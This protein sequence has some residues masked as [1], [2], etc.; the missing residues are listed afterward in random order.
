[1]RKSIFAFSMAICLCLALFACGKSGQAGPAQLRAGTYTGTG[2]GHGGDIEVE[3]TVDGT[4]RI[5]E[6]KILDEDETP[7]YAA[8][9]LER[10]PRR[11]IEEQRLDLDAVA[12]ATLSSHGVLAAVADAVAKAGGDPKDFG[13]TSLQERTDSGDIT[14]TGLP[15]GDFKLTGA[16]LKK[17]YALSE[18]DAIS[19]NSKGTEKQVHA[20]GVLLETIL[21]KL[22]ADLMDFNAVTATASDGYTITIPREVLHG[23]DILIAFETNGEAIDPRF[24]VPGERA[25]YWVKL[26]SEIAFEK[27]MEEVPV[28]QEIDLGA[29]IEKLKDQAVDYE[30]KDAQCKAIPIALLLEEIGAEELS[31]V[32]L[33]SADG[34]TKTEK[35][36]IFAGQ[37]L[38]VEGTP[39][40][41]LYTGPDLPAGMR[42][43][44]VESFQ[45]GGTLVMMLM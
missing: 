25:M 4:G 12:G 16:Q 22:G 28:T 21:Q 33:K 9:A 31:V 41:P 29:L 13:F 32:T 23:R 19:I 17:D 42:L 6:V 1:M 45:V 5:V 38:V 15:G 10:L 36:E 14:F 43:K 30:Y 34:L 26:L 20:V 40:A 7:D 11:I 27:A 8:G 44:N 18:V 37:L 39:E 3:L 24:V 2:T 35:Y